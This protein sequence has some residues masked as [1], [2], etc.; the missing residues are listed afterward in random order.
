MIVHAYHLPGCRATDDDGVLE[1]NGVRAVAP[2]LTTDDLQRICQTLVA[3]RA[4]LTE[5][6]LTRI[7]AAIDATA[8]RLRDPDAPDYDAL[9][10]AIAAFTGY[11]TAM[12][13]HVLDR[14]STDWLAAPLHRL[15][16]DEFGGPDAID[17]FIERA[18]GIRARAVAPPLT[19]HVFSGNVPGVSVTSMVR[20]LLVKS[21]VLG[22]SAAGEPFLAARFAQRL[23]QVDPAIGACLA[24]T[25][26]SGGDLQLEATALQ[27]ANAVVHYGAATAIASLR[28]RA[29]AH[30]RFIEHG[31]RISFAIVNAAIVDDEAGG[32]AAR[33]LARA[34]ALFEQQGC[35]SPQSA[36]VVGNEAAAARRFAARVASALEDVQREFPRGIIDAAE[37]TAVRELRTNAEFRAIRGENVELWTGENLAWTV[38]LDTAPDFAGTCLN[39]TLLV[40][41]A[42]AWDDVVAHL[43]PFGTLL[44]TVGVA[45]FESQPLHE[46]ATALTDAGA[47]RVTSLADMPWPPVSW[48]HDGRG[49]LTELIR[50]ADFEL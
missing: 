45:G 36:Y 46:L 21:A 42:T 40:K 3:A 16:H 44:Q 28:A 19:F 22:K 27:H 20:A 34:V 48:H 23:A 7:I 47:T 17:A 11:S 38:V 35:V 32:R 4:Q 12:A 5:M 43:R 31:P 50:W 14:M 15:V 24:I 25:Y 29:P 30:V 9:I 10:N 33:E 39:R 6:P 49:P 26:W 1:R 13:V 18:D 2:R 8:R 41:H 37:A